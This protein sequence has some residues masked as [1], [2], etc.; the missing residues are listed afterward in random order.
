MN[1]PKHTIL[2]VDDT[3]EDCATYQRFL[4][5]DQEWHYEFLLA[6][7]G[8]RGAEL[9]RETPPS[10]VLLDYRLPDQSGLEVLAA[11]AN[12]RG[13]VSCPVV[14]LTG[15][16]EVELA[17]E[18]MKLGAQDFIN[19]NR[20][21]PLDLQRA[22][23]NAVE[24]VR[25]RLEVQERERRFGMLAETIPQL[26]MTNR[27]DGACD[28][29]S[30]RWMKYTGTTL[31]DNLGDGWQQALHPDEKA[32][33]Q[34]LWAQAVA[35]GS[36]CESEFRMRR[37]D[38]V[39]RW[40]LARAVAMKN[41]A[42]RVAKWVGSC[43]DIE[44]R[45]QA[46]EVRV[47]LAAI[48]ESSSDAI[49]AKDL[50]GVITSWNAGA[51]RLF[52]YPEAEAI[53]QPI[54]MLI[55]PE[56]H[57]EEILILSRLRVG[58]RIEH[59]ET[60]RVNQRGERL[61]VS[62]TIS[63]LRDSSG[64]VIGVAKIARDITE[65]KRI[66]A[67]R[68]QL[69]KREQH[70]RTLA[71]NANRLKDEFL[72]TLSHELRTPLNH[73]Y[74][75]VKMIRTGQLPPVEVTRGLEV[76]ERNLQAQNRLIDDLLDVSRIITGRVRLDMRAVEL[77]EVIERAVEAIRPAAD[78]K[79]VQLGSLEF[80]MR[81][82][83]EM[84][85]QPDDATENEK[86]AL[87]TPH[88]AIITGDPDRLQQVVWNLVSNAIKFTPPGGHV[89]LGL[90]RNRTNVI[91][92]VSDTGEGVTPEFL[93]YVFDRFSQQDG[94]KTRRHG[95][96][97]LGL[98][99]VRH[100]VELHGGQVSVSS[101]GLGQG[102]TFTVILP[103]RQAAFELQLDGMAQ[104]APPEDVSAHYAPP[105]TILQGIKVLAVDD[106]PDALSLLDA[107]LTPTGAEVRTAGGMT[108]AL[109]ILHDWTPD[110]L[111]SDIGM[112]NGDGYELIRRV[113]ATEQSQT[114]KFPAVALTAYAS[115]EDRLQALVA[116][117][118]MHV[119]KPVEP[120][121]LITILASL[122]GRLGLGMNGEP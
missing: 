62:L 106:E 41:G 37:A 77:T 16:D 100:L 13:E 33:L 48:V 3:P 118:Q 6:E 8:A 84:A 107:L 38:G 57:A 11:L 86:S 29:V 70:A 25:L 83:E 61:D 80:G 113:H 94:S 76:V 20:L 12:E 28:Y 67:E 60:V 1:G 99:I 88:S 92:V 65:R 79:G 82:N 46:E 26:V 72:A 101:P 114:A 49:I 110:V 34:E 66:E 90:E 10:C 64:K 117:Y 116:G 32:A 103:V 31:E 23:H 112:P 40:H 18:A 30:H 47:R 4:R 42:G 75:W 36:D 17:V 51:T 35:T 89:Q 95:G 97:G 87:R 120:E 2:I 102:A 43:T 27:A 109:S 9:C 78:A 122:T 58:E 45:K 7:N 54:F 5:Q 21:T 85:R 115:A 59:Y 56:L 98:A 74:G 39:Y 52:G 15:T 63:P 55:P 121:E 91:L 71:E 111:V 73:S 105:S 93:P 24:R 14:M 22:V 81:N 96:L 53:G 68:E 119:A 104:T 50:T 108:Q 69:L 44:E 19:K